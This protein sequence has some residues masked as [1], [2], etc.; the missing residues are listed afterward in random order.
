MKEAVDAQ[1]GQEKPTNLET[2]LE[3]EEEFIEVTVN[4]FCPENNKLRK[5]GFYMGDWS[6]YLAQNVVAF[7]NTLIVEIY[8]FRV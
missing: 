4:I 2:V 6:V 7:I 5:R 3:E 1:R 8:Y